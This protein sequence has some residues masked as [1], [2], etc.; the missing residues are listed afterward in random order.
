MTALTDIYRCLK[1]VGF[2]KG[3]V[4][5]LLPEWWEPDMA[6]S[7]S[8]LQETA[9]L[10]GRRLNLSATALLEGRAERTI[11]LSV[12]RY[13][14][15]VRVSQEQLVPA[16]LIAS[17]LAKAIVGA[18]PDRDVE[19]ARNAATVRKQILAPEG[20]R[21]DFD[22]LLD[23]CWSRG[24]PVIPL[25]N[26]PKGVRKMDAAAI[27][28]GQRPAILIAL[29]NNSK[30]WLSFLLA[31]E[32][33]HLCLNHVPDNAALVEGSLSDSAE[34]DAES[35]IDT[36]EAEANDFASALLAGREAE[37]VVQGWARGLPAVTLATTAR[38]AANEF[39]TA[40]G[41]LVLRYAFVTK[42]WPD[43]RIALNFL[44]DD[45]DAQATLV[46]R[47]QKEV[48]T[49]QIGDDLSDYVLQITGVAPQG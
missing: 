5:S 17:S 11:D 49:N 13:K 39:R 42:R 31:H 16:T 32:L 35:Q 47:L 3:Q 40:P 46:Q 6:R 41:H 25:P 12:P 23:Y 18:M 10:L 28:V 34:F 7:A 48:D 21:M 45:M 27:K 4:V 2:T 9:L 15:T 26:L 20:A 14:H 36:Q 1:T 37:S 8:G 30:A 44:A 38:R 19:L 33:G 22:A 43:A 24:V 29:R